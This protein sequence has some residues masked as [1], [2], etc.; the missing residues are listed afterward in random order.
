MWA[1][2]TPHG[3]T[4]VGRIKSCNDKYIFVVYKCGDLWENYQ[5][6]TGCATNPED[7]KPIMRQC[8]YSKATGCSGIQSCKRCE[9][10]AEYLYLEEES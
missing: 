7:L 3:T 6:Y 4:E 10:K 5:D 9:T 2:G 8:P 1:V